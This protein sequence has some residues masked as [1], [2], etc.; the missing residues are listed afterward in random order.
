MRTVISKIINFIET[1]IWRIRANQLS[2]VKC[3]ALRQLRIILLAVR[4]FAEDNCM[5]R[6]S[7]LT[8]FSLLSIVPVFA[9]A[10]GIAKGFGFEQKLKIL[11]FEN[12]QGQEEVVEKIIGF[13][14][15]MLEDTQG[16]L[17]AGIGTV[18]LFWTVIKVLG[19]IEESFNEIWGIKKSRSLGRKFSDY[20]SIMLICPILLIISS[21]VTVII[22]SQVV[23]LMDQLSFL[24]P[25][26]PLIIT[27]LKIL[28]YVVIWALFIFMY[29]FIPNAKINFQAGLLGGIVAGTIYQIVQ[30]IYIMFQVG[31]LKYG[32]IYGSFAA[33]PLFLVWLQM[34]WLIVLLGAEVSFAQQNVQT[35]EFEPDCLKTSH[36]FKRLIALYIVQL[37]V[38]NFCKGE[39]PWHADQIAH[40]LGFPIRLV[41]H[42]LFEL[43][44]AGLLVEVKLS[45]TATLFY[46]PA[47]DP[48]WLTI[49]HVLQALDQYGIDAVPSINSDEFNKLEETFKKFKTAIENSPSN[50]ALKDL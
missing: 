48:E 38:K 47:R 15:A 27:S 50:I 26:V 44:E 20:T 24:G 31:V 4:G 2:G 37:S 42:I 3:F 41:R 39:K 33:L 12:L 19:Q 40:F 21:S 13:S 25:I 22:S 29:I 46:Q 49:S 6:A 11:L 7:A 16:G 43:T 18:V 30:W 34:S 36:S 14:Q 45:D 35:Y 17:I 5:L 1:D 9:M 23:L 32:A 28:P 8:F 10:F